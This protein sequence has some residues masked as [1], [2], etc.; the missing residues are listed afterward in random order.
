MGFKGH[1]NSN[2]HA[3]V[4]AFAADLKRHPFTQEERASFAWDA[5][6]YVQDVLTEFM[7]L[8]VTCDTLGV[9]LPTAPS[10][11]IV[12]FNADDRWEAVEL[13]CP[14]SYAEFAEPQRVTTHV[15]PA[16]AA[17]DVEVDLGG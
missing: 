17:T 4:D 16:E 6:G 2:L 7:S 14:D 8:D 10:E 15:E 1:V 3:A 11:T 13:Q 12:I 5:L 9:D